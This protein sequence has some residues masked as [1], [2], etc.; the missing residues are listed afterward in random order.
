MNGITKN[1]TVSNRFLINFVTEF[2]AL[3]LINLY[4]IR[5]LSKVV[6]SI[7]TQI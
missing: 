1:K 3:I 5:F 6:R 4:C 2:I 7:L